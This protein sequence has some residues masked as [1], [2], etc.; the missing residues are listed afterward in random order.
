MRLTL[1]ELRELIRE[2]LNT[3]DFKKGDRVLWGK[4]KNRHGKITNV[5]M[6]DK[7][8]VSIDIDSVPKGKKKTTSLYTVRHDDSEEKEE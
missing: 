8:N 1:R 7:N 4:Y 3:G 2:A 6:D 5:A